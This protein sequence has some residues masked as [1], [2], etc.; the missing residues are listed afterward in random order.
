[1][2]HV[3][4]GEQQQLAEIDADCMLGGMCFRH[5]ALS[6]H[7]KFHHPRVMI[8]PCHSTTHLGIFHVSYR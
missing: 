1:M 5:A 2:H 8:V 6:E 3:T 4:W 7:G